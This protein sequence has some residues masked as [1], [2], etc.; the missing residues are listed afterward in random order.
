MADQYANTPPS[1]AVGP[2]GPE[3]GPATA[4]KVLPW[5]LAYSGGRIVIAVALVG[6]LWSVGLGSFPGVLFGL[7]LSMPVSYVLLRPVREK[8]TEALAA[9]SIAKQELRARLRGTDADDAA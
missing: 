1:P 5:A 8:L 6:L 9:R 7:L 4:P 3:G 2:V